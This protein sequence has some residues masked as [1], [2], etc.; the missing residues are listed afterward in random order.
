MF[1]EEDEE[2]F[3]VDSDNDEDEDF[4]VDDEEDE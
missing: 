1:W 4:E 2:D 3:E